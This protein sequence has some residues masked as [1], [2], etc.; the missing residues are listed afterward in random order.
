MAAE[1]SITASQTAN[2]ARILRQV[3]SEGHEFLN[4]NS[5]GARLKLV[6]CAREL[7]TAASSPVETLLWNIW[8]LV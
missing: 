4:G 7:V 8:A 2:V 5:E 6:D 3:A 1:S